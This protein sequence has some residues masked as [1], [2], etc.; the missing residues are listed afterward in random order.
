MSNKLPNICNYQY[1]LLYFV[2]ENLNGN[3]V[4]NQN[5]TA[6]KNKFVFV[7]QTAEH[8]V[9]LPVDDEMFLRQNTSS[10][11]TYW[12]IDCVF[13]DQ[14]V[15]F[16]LNHTY[17]DSMED[18]KIDA[19]VVGNTHPLP[20]LPT[21]TAAPITTPVTTTTL[22]PNST[23]TVLPVTTP[24]DKKVVKRNTRSV[25]KK[26]LDD[27][28]CNKNNMIPLDDSYIYGHYKLDI[29]VR[30]K[31]KSVIK[32]ISSERNMILHHNAFV[33]RRPGVARAVFNLLEALATLGE[34]DPY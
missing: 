28:V 27:F 21:T 1:H 10:I 16:K 23:T 30:G 29:S 22:K 12:F 6:L 9:S 8:S 11:V 13:K 18:H 24:Q 5:H 7:N 32:K 34:W 3:I 14:T 26:S 25:K 4:I 2:S 17:I 15:G 19:L 31:Y 20:P 33:D